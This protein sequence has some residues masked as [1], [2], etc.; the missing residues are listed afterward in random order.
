MNK[1]ASRIQ[2]STSETRARRLLFS[3]RTAATIDP[4]DLPVDHPQ[5]QHMQAPIPPELE[6]E[7]FIPA[8]AK[9]TE[10]RH[11]IR[12]EFADFS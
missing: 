3:T 11:R 5:H 12:G 1:T 2:T 8:K 9:D 7:A 10:L 6:V 4:P